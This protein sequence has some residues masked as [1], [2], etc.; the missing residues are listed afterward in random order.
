VLSK[1]VGETS[2][3]GVKVRVEEVD[4]EGDVEPELVGWGLGGGEGQLEKVCGA[5][6]GVSV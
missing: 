2:L 1:G 4:T 6:E 5:S 3:E